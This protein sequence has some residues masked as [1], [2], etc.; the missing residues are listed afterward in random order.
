MGAKPKL[1]DGIDTFNKR[2]V[3]LA[4]RV[5]DNSG[6][7]LRKVSISVLSAIVFPTPVKEGRAKGNWLVGV[8]KAV[9]RTVPPRDLTGNAAI[10]EGSGVIAG[11][12]AD[13]TVYVSNNLAYIQLLDDPGI[14]DQAPSGFVDEAVR[15]GVNAVVSANLTS[16]TGE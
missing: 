5:Q 16:P 15:A 14:S 4:K 7:T 3:V 10:S 11:V 2:I 13:D 6:K 8:N 1:K 12:E 9:R